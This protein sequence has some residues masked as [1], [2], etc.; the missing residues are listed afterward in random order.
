MLTRFGRLDAMEMDKHA[1]WIGATLGNADVRRRWF[2]DAI[3]FD[4]GARH[5]FQFLFDVLEHCDD[6]RAAL[7]LPAPPLADDA[8][9]ER[10]ALNASLGTVFGLERWNVPTIK[11]PEGTSVIAAQR[12]S[13]G[14]GLHV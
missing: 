8:R 9:M 7:A 12:R 5:D 10:P 6:D 13:P 4:R 2:P 1:S 14:G 11:L 3:Q